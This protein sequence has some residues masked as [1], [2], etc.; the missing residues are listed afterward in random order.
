MKK[1][2]IDPG[3]CADCAVC[4]VAENCPA[5]AIIREEPADKPWIDS[6]HCRGCMKCK[7]VCEHQAV[8]EE[9]TPCH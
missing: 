5:K 3:K 9:I 6:Y 1:A 4:L 8:T 2:L 7:A